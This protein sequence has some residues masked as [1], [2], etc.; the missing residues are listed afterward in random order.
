MHPSL[1]ARQPAIALMEPVAL[2]TIQ[3][4]LVT[5]FIVLFI[6]VFIGLLLIVVLIV[7]LLMTNVQWTSQWFAIL[8]FLKS[9]SSWYVYEPSNIH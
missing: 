2:Q 4:I 7:F 3:G 1:Y 8:N 9:C 6:A 5:V